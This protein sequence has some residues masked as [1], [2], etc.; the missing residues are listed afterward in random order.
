MVGLRLK[1]IFVVQ[2]RIGI[3]LYEVTFKRKLILQ[4]FRQ[5][6]RRLKRKNDRQ[7]RTK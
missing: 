2:R 7:F 6:A 5:E 1:K 4:R 3:P